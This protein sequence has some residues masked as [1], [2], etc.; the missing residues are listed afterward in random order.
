MK[1][2]CQLAEKV[3]DEHG[4]NSLTVHSTVAG[5]L[6]SAGPR[7]RDPSTAIVQPTYTTSAVHQTTFKSNWD[8]GIIG[9]KMTSCFS[10][11]C[12]KSHSSK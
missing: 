1:T 6:A 9:Q 10:C 3:V 4:I 12:S 7:P 11:Y 2:R 8:F 5:R